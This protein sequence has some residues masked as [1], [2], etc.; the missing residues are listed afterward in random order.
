MSWFKEDGLRYDEKG[1]ILRLDQRVA[2]KLNV[3]DRFYDVVSERWATLLRVRPP[4][5]AMGA[6]FEALYDGCDRFGPFVGT[7]MHADIGEVISA[8][9]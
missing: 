1:R 3:G 4:E 8:Q 6:P 2:P 5:E 9:F 7:A